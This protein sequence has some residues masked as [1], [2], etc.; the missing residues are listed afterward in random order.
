MRLMVYCCHSRCTLE[1]K[2]LHAWI[3]STVVRALKR[4]DGHFCACAPLMRSP[5]YSEGGI[6]SPWKCRNQICGVNEQDE[7]LLT[8]KDHLDRT[9]L[10]GGAARAERPYTRRPAFDSF[11]VPPKGA[12]R[13]VMRP[14]CGRERGGC[15]Q[16]TRSWVRPHET[17][18][19]CAA[20]VGARDGRVRPRAG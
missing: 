11:G 16:L 10:C 5:N 7:K 20:L 4:L 12:D 1:S 8:A 6:N 14:C 13:L 18:F 3:I 19:H 2:R 9:A 17:I 15:L